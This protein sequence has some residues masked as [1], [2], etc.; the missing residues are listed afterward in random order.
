MKLKTIIL[1]AAGLCAFAL[2]LTAMQHTQAEQ[3]KLSAAEQS[4]LNWEFLKAIKDN[5]LK[6]AQEALNKGADVN[7]FN[8]AAIL[9]AIDNRN[10]NAT[11]LL[12]AAPHINVNWH[13]FEGS[14]T[15]FDVLS[16][17]L[18]YYPKTGL[19]ILKQLLATG[20]FD[21][22]LKNSNGLTAL[23]LAILRHSPIEAIRL[24]LELPSVNVNELF[25]NPKTTPLHESAHQ[26]S[27]AYTVAERRRLSNDTKDLTQIEPL[28]AIVELL[29]EHGADPY[30]KNGNGFNVFSNA[31][32]DRIS[33]CYIKNRKEIN[34]LLQNGRES[35]LL[36]AQE[37]KKVLDE[38]LLLPGPVAN[39]V[40]EYLQGETKKKKS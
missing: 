19:I 5:D 36:A 18:K 33:R 23:P 2:P 39:V 28:T 22:N 16:D 13:S 15:L 26:L 31:H 8:H 10:V 4:E 35:Y 9:N 34:D 17:K 24:L 40:C 25:G 3:K 38:N 14:N 37:A 32:Y 6:K 11:A 7:D 21:P 30:I 12:F 27:Q 20:K 29:L 1:L